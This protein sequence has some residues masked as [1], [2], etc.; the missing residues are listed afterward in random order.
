MWR[1]N[2]KICTALNLW[3]AKRSEKAQQVVEK[4]SN[5]EG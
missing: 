4:E 5:E 3:A 2:K 1:S